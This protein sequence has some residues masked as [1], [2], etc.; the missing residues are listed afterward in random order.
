ME[1]LLNEKEV[2]NIVSFK[3]TRLFEMIKAGDFP[4][5]IKF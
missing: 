5:P 2:S 4:K 3:R 1:K